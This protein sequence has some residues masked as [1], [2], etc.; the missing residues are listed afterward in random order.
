MRFDPKTPVLA[1]DEFQDYPSWHKGR[2]HY[3]VWYIEIVGDNVL[4]YCKQM[5]SQF[6]QILH[7]GYRRQFHITLFVNG[8][9][10]DAPI[11]DDDCTLA[12]IAKQAQAI[13]RLKLPAFELGVKGVDGF[14]SSLFLAI[15]DW[16]DNLS[17]IRQALGGIKSE[18]A[19]DNYC[20][21]ITLGFYRQGIT[22]HQVLTMIQNI[23]C[24]PQRFWVN[25]ITVGHY[26][27]DKLQ[28][29]L[30]PIQR[31]DLF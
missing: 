4:S 16:A 14:S 10:A 30:T 20:P 13:Q 19:P 3:V 8:F 17:R 11:Y 21:H 26:Q 2:W 9:L 25:Q 28:G 23:P 12:Q 7:D 24:P 27:A 6:A 15:D 18:I 1:L 29:E 5:Q 22:S 31:I